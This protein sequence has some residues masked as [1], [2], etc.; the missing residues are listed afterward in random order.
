V[1]YLGF[2]CNYFAWRALHSGVGSMRNQ[3]QGTGA[4]LGLLNAVFFNA[5]HFGIDRPVFA[6]DSRKSYRKQI[7]PGYKDRPPKTV[8]D[9]EDRRE[10]YRQI[11]ELRK[12]ILPSIGFKNIFQ[13]T[14]L[15]ADDILARL[16]RDNP[17][18]FVILTADEDML[19]LVDDCTW[20]SPSS[21][22]LMNEKSFV[23]KY[24]IAPR[25]WR[26]VKAIA[27][28]TSDK[29]KGVVQVGEKT[30]LKYLRGELEKD[31]IARMIIDDEKRLIKRNGKLVNLPHPKT[32]P[33][34]IQEDAF[35][36]EGFLAICDLYGFEKLSEKVYE[37]EMIF[38]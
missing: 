13:Q 1:K 26:R 36:A 10:V 24:G 21:K 5:K 28:C 15:E 37:W 25:E 22:L 35:S 6:F 19:Q 17:K 29:I 11:I 38:R 4:I 27:G 14:G 34:T 31:S 16:V 12:T 33:M 3:N 23:K 2:D 9:L 8:K 7:F 32:K 30:A 20:Y 18:Q